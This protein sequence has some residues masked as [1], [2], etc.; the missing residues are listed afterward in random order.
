ML[1]RQLRLYINDV[2]KL[3]IYREYLD[4]LKRTRKYPIRVKSKS[5]Y[6]I[7]YR[8]FSYIPRYSYIIE[9][10]VD[11]MYNFIVPK[12][13]IFIKIDYIHNEI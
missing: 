10:L 5:N 6:Y 9:N 12:L 8:L 7:R 11:K 3:P 1:I 2:I 13:K 4:I